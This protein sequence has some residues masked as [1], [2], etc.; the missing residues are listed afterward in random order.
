MQTKEM[1]LQE[2]RK[3]FEK[4]GFNKT[5]MADIA[6]AARK[7][8]RTIYTYF[9]SK[10]EVFRAVIEVEVK[11]LASSLQEIIN[12]MLPANEKLRKYMRIR[13]NAVKE[14]TVYY[15]A[16]RQ[17]LMNNLG[18]IENLRKEYDLLETSMIK[19][20]LDEGVEQNEFEI[21]N[22][23][24]VAQSIVLASKGFELPIFMN[25]QGYDPEP[26]IDPLISLLYNGI[27]KN[28]RN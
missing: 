2:A 16:L 6:L 23:Q 10:E 21:E 5:S 18:M 9:T 4:F 25:Q 20:I 14:L 7:G 17:D 27:L 15:D 12:S 19:T 1:I 13:M 26:F 8:R 3:V 11:A 24:L 28:K 22:T